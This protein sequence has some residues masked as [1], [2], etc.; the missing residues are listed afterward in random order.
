MCAQT[1][2][3]DRKIEFETWIGKDTQTNEKTNTKTTTKYFKCAK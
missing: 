3:E 1:N 2:K